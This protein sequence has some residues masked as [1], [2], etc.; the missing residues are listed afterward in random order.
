MPVIVKRGAN[1]FLI[2]VSKSCLDVVEFS[3]VSGIYVYMSAIVA[4]SL[5]AYIVCVQMCKMC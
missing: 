1:N 5:C 3:A 2:D 4:D